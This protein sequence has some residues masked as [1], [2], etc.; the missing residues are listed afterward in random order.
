MMAE[1][2]KDLLSQVPYFA[3]LDEAHLR[4]LA[5]AA[6]RR[7]YD[8]GQ[9]VLLEGEPCAGMQIVESGWLRSLKMSQSG[10]EQTL[11]VVGPGEVFSDLTL[12]AGKPN[13]VTVVALE[14]AE[15]LF[16]PADPVLA[17]L[18]QPSLAR[19]V[20][21]N[22]ASRALQLLSLVEDLSLRTVSARLARLLLE[23]SSEDVVPRRRWATQA[24]MASRLGTVPDVLNRALQSLAAEGLIDVDRQQIKICD[25][26][27]LEAKAELDA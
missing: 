7:H 5:D 8:K 25:R 20:I 18:D 13:Q 6:R 17:L 1:T 21:Q 19:L 14:P 2:P 24:E 27:G 23:N 15:V 16:V 26:A 4:S 10:R 22:L 9:I 12:F 3:G 11:R